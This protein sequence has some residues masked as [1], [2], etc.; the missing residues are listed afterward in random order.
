MLRDIAAGKGVL[1]GQTAASPL[2]AVVRR[3]RPRR[4]R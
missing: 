2:A 4:R 3:R 1:P